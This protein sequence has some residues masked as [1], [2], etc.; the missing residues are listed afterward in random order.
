MAKIKLTKG[1]L[2]KQRDALIQ[3][4]RYLPTLQLKKQQLQLEIIYHI[5][6]LTERKRAEEKKREALKSWIVLMAD[7]GV[8]ISKWIKPKDVL[9]QVKNIAGVD[10]PVFTEARFEFAEYDLFSTPLWVDSGIDALRA[11]ASLKSEIAVIEEGVRILRRELRVTSQR[12]NLFEKVKIPQ[13]RE[14]IRLIKIYIGDQMA[15]A[16]GRSKIAKRKI[17]EMVFEEVAA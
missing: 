16:V 8:D 5:N 17:K 7:P 3:Y 13:A 12:V 14:A 2:K 15:N 11:L 1:E 9:T 4:E 6:I 10:I